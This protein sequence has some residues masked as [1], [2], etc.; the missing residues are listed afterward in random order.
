MEQ[1]AVEKEEGVKPSSKRVRLTDYDTTNFLGL[2]ALKVDGSNRWRQRAKCLGQPELTPLFFTDYPATKAYTRAHMLAE[3]Q[4]FCNKCEVRKECF[5]FAKDNEIRHGIWGGV[6]FY[7][8]SN[9]TI[10]SIIPDS[11]D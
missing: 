8:A 11:I 3:A 10:R 4:E 1:V 7:I 9:G 5:K 2:P 6:D